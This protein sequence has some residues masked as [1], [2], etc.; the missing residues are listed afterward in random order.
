M[1]KDEL[2]RVL[3]GQYTEPIRD[4]LWQHIYLSPGFKRLV[5]LEPFQKLGR[6]KQL[7]PSFHVYPGAVHTR[8]NH[9]LGVF[10][11]ARK[12]LLALVDQTES[13]PLSSEG[14]KA[15]LAASL[16][17]DLGHFPFAH[18]LKELPLKDHEEL[19]AEKILAEPL[20]SALR[21]EVGTDPEMVAQIVDE[22]L[23]VTEKTEVPL[24]R[25][26]LS[27][28]LDPDKLDYL[29]RDAFFC[30]VPYGVQDTEFILHKLHLHEGRAIALEYEG[31]TAV[32]NVLFSKY[33][34]YRN[35]YWHRVVR[36]ATAMIKQAIFTA[37][38]EGKIAAEQ[39]Y[40]LDDEEFYRR[41]RVDEH[42]ALELIPQ[43]M[44]RRFF[45]TAFE[46][47]FDSGNPGHL[48]LTDL[49]SRFL[50]QE[51]IARRLNRR[52]H[53][54]VKPHEV[55]IDIPEPISFEID[56]PIIRNGEGISFSH[57]GSLFNGP[58]VEGFTRSLRML[59]LFVPADLLDKIQEP[60]Q[61]F[62]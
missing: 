6:I 43:V 12:L 55:I 22:N 30:G 5:A 21:E 4:P 36:I 3:V 57:S 18:S 29:N 60:E 38:R 31:I 15:F 50:K 62:E 61:Y 34:M 45:K 27:G 1:G 24:Y 28:V 37:L 8:L 33:L 48:A 58:A 20:Y 11:L 35:V 10:H 14:I 59:R 17:H 26:F 32:E 2:F 56:L 23:P 13:L 7:G 51:E 41:F 25:N 16:L 47:A 53:R 46:T 39:L 54:Q 19:T 9:S 40:W 52:L 42:E 44:H 49:E